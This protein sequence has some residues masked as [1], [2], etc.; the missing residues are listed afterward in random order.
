MSVIDYRMFTVP[1]S[2][3]SLFGLPV[4]NHTVRVEP[5]HPHRCPQAIVS[6]SFPPLSTDQ[7]ATSM[8]IAPRQLGHVL[9]GLPEDQLTVSNDPLSVHT[10]NPRDG[11]LRLQPFQRKSKLA[12]VHV[13][14]GFLLKRVQGM[15]KLP[16]IVRYF[17]FCTDSRHGGCG[18]CIAGDGCSAVCK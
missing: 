11:I 2:S 5:A 10:C 17:S 13:Y 9:Q 4:N 12:E 15:V 1:A 8:L 6:P 18:R 7:Q 3:Q 16:S 14:A